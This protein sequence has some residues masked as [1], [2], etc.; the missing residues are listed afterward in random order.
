MISQA[1][2]VASCKINSSRLTTS[3]LYCQAIVKYYSNNVATFNSSSVTNQCH[4]HRCHDHQIASDP[5]HHIC[6]PVITS[7][8]TSPSCPPPADLVYQ[9]LP[10]YTTHCIVSL[11]ISEFAVSNRTL[12]EFSSHS[13]LSFVAISITS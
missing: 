9:V 13:F 7:E 6:Q 8:E 4:H 2:I 3:Y 5:C 10:R 11:P 12:G 1:Q